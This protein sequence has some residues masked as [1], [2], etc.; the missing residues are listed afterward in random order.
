MMNLCKLLS[1][2]S[3]KQ[4]LLITF[5]VT[6]EWLGYIGSDPKP[7]NIRFASIPN[8]VPPERL[9]AA[10]F[11]GFYEA[12]MTKMEAPFE[13]LLDELEQ[14]V[15]AMLGDVE[16][17]W[18]ISVGNRRNIPVASVWT[19]PAVFFS[20]L[21]HWNLFLPNRHLPLNSLGKCYYCIHVF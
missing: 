2:K 4:H 14:P 21:H 10:D 12:V 3:K 16:L 11:P 9:K 19:M 17:L 18:T 1:S 6:E 15:D 5:V 20:M 13:K 7:N 8:V